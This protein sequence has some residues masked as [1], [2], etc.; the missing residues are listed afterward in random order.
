MTYHADDLAPSTPYIFK[1]GTLVADATGV[2]INPITGAARVLRVLPT[3]NIDRRNGLIYLEEVDRKRRH[4]VL[5]GS[6]RA[7]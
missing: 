1:P 7:A 3:P 5:V 6:L 2:I 4:K